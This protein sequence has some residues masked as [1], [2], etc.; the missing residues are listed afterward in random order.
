MSK[1]TEYVNDPEPDITVTSNQINPIKYVEYSSLLPGIPSSQG[2]VSDPDLINAFN[3]IQA[4]D[5]SSGYQAYE[6]DTGK[7]Y[8]EAYN[9]GFIEFDNIN[10]TNTAGGFETSFASGANGGKIE[11]RVD[12]T[13]GPLLGECKLPNTGW[14]N[15]VTKAYDLDLVKGVHS[16]FLIF[17]IPNDGVFQIDWFKFKRPTIK[18]PNNKPVLPN[19]PTNINE[20][21]I[22]AD[23]DEDS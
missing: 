14:D 16:I 22:Q 23:I 17:N 15:F 18:I 6:S 8:V 9:K 10:F 1:G 12:S 20:Y 2:P 11:I 13:D 5:Y 19:I 4:E 3:V 7:S 21:D